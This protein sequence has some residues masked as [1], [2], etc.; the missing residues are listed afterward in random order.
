MANGS[1]LQFG[2]VARTGSIMNLTHLKPSCQIC[3]TLQGTTL[4]H[5]NDYTITTGDIS[6]EIDFN[7]IKDQMDRNGRKTKKFRTVI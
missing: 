7:H 2:A 6:E 1:S 5:K 3:E 4:A